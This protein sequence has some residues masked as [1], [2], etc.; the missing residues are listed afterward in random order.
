M[1]AGAGSALAQADDGLPPSPNQPTKL[2][3]APHF[4]WATNLEL[5]QIDDAN[6]ES[7]TSG[8][9]ALFKGS[10]Y[11]L[12]PG[13]HQLAFDTQTH[14]ILKLALMTLPGHQYRITRSGSFDLI[15]QDETN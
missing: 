8:L 7:L 11:S 6:V 13:E 12:P 2:I 15:V 9:T 14:V 3:V 4:G 5:I 1:L 10:D